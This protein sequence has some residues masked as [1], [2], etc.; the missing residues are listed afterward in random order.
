MIS[1]KKESDPENY[2]K[3]EEEFYETLVIP[4]LFRTVTGKLEKSCF[5][6]PLSTQGMLIFGLITSIF[7]LHPPDYLIRLTK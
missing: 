3:H 5:A 7:V 6:N 2:K 1:L 4:K